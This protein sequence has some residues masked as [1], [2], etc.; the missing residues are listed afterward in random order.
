MKTKCTIIISII[1]FTCSLSVFASDGFA[2]K[3]TGGAGGQS[4]TVTTGAQLNTYATASGAYIITV[5]GTVTYSG[6]IQITSNKTIQGINAS[7]TVNAN[8]YCGSSTKNVIIRNLNITNPS[9]VGDGDGITVTGATNVFIDHCTFTDCSDGECDIVLKADSVTLSWCRFRYVNQTTHKYVNLIGN[10][11]GAT[12]DAGKLHVTI[13]H[14]WYDQNCSE[15]MPSVRFGTVHVFNN[16]YRSDSLNYCARTRLSAQVLV[17]GNYFDHV[18]NPWE[19][20]VTAGTTTGRLYAVNNNVTYLDTS[21]GVQWLNGW[22]SDL[23]IT[24][25]LIPGTDSVFTPPYPY[26]LTNALDVKDSVMQYAGNVASLFAVDESSP[27]RYRFRLSQNYPNPFNPSTDIVFTMQYSGNII[28]KVFNVLGNEVAVLVNERRMA[29]EYHE[30][31]NATGLPSGVY[32]YK[33]TAGNFS[34]TK[35]MLLLK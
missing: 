4:I 5:S 35:K 17:E 7:A 3:T 11:D 26:R 2:Y 27:E 29:G 1:V 21:F 15:R 28:L 13:H 10:S 25:S 12:G 31:F 16:Y 30:A 20:A 24:Q 9:G 33:L 18:K 34:E 6:D 8:L 23:S 19:L 14:C 32:F 22:Y